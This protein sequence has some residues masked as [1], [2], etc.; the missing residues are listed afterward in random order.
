MK[1]HKCCIFASFTWPCSRLVNAVSQI[2]TKPRDFCVNFAFMTSHSGK[3]IT[4]RE[5]LF[6]AGYSKTL[7]MAF[8]F[9]VVSLG[10]AAPKPLE[11][12]RHWH[13]RRKP[14]RGGVF[15]APPRLPP[16]CASGYSLTGCAPT[17]PVSASSDVVNVVLFST[18]AKSLS[19]LSSCLLQFLFAFREDLLLTPIKPYARR[20][21]AYRAVKTNFIVVVNVHF[22]FP[23]CLVVV[24]KEF[25][26]DAFAFERLVPSFNLAVALRVVHRCRHVRVAVKS[27]ELGKLLP[28]ELLPVVRDESGV[29]F[30]KA[31]KCQ[32]LHDAHVTGLH[33]AEEP[34]CD[35]EA[36]AAVND[37]D[38]V[39]GL[40]TYMDISDVHVP[41][42]VDLQRLLEACPLARR[43]ALPVPDDSMTA[44]N[45]VDCGGFCI[46]DVGVHHHVRAT[47]VSILNVLLVEGDDKTAFLLSQPVPVRKIASVPVG[48]AQAV[49]P[50]MEP[51]PGDADQE[52]Q[53]CVIHTGTF[54]PFFNECD[55]PVAKVELNPAV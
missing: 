50:V 22:D 36:A 49:P 41:V 21:I 35:Y 7:Q 24:G 14:E 13:I 28:D 53:M 48:N 25:P 27:D 15:K 3:R 6:C 30:R 32:L 45:L 18:S 40:A 33:C 16:V 31:F 1:N 51:L 17:E 46:H 52:A 26:V 47:P 55:N 38:H 12:F 42:L 54:M 20:H 11:F 9:F 5:F 34:P 23:D 43:H 19:P 44:K 2:L 37:R 10:G 4:W 39:V 8:R 29:R